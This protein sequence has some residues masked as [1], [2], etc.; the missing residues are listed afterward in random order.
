MDGFKLGRKRKSP[1]NLF[2][3]LGLPPGERALLLI[4]LVPSPLFS[5]MS[6]NIPSNTRAPECHA[7]AT[8]DRVGDLYLDGDAVRLPHVH[9]A[10]LAIK[11][12]TKDLWTALKEDIRVMHYTTIKPFF[13]SGCLLSRETM[14]ED[15]DRST[16]KM[17]KV[18]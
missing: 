16:G 9:N 10:N 1:V 4:Q 2:V 13:Y 11:T 12:R 17:W 15:M 5:S 3:G 14:Q 6:S 7:P 18:L 8:R